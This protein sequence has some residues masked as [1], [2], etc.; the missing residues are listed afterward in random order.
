MADQHAQCPKCGALFW[1]TDAHRDG[2][3]I[4]CVEGHEFTLEE[5]PTFRFRSAAKRRKDLQG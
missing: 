2:G 5:C 4:R 3:T 1:V